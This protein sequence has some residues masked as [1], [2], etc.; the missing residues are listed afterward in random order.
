MHIYT[1]HPFYDWRCDGSSEYS[2]APAECIKRREVKHLIIRY[3]TSLVLVG[4]LGLEIRL[5]E[6]HR[7]R[8]LLSAQPVQTN[9]TE[10]ITVG[11]SPT[12]KKREPR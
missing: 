2:F 3:L 1:K 9:G 6:T 5:V 11:A 7:L 12:N 10:E 4:H 8:C